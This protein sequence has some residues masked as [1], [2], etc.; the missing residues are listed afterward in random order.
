MKIFFTM[1]LLAFIPVFITSLLF[2]VFILELMDLFSN[3]WRYLAHDATIPSILTVSLLYL[4]KCISYALPISLLFSVS[5]TLGNLYMNNE[6]VA[7][8]AAGVSLYSL[9]IPFLLIGLISSIAIFFFDNS[10]VIDTLR[11]KNQL[12]RTLVHMSVS[13]SNTNVTVISSDTRVIYQSDYYND[14]KETLTK[15]TLII[16][17]EHFNFKSRID[18]D[19]GEWQQN[20][21]VFHNCRIIEWNPAHTQLTHRQ[22]KRLDSPELNEKPSTFRKTTRRIEEMKQNEALKWVQSLKQA[23]LPYRHALTEYYKKFFMALNPFIVA[24]ISAGIGSAFK[25]NILLMHLLTALILSVIYYVAQMI[26]VILSKG[27]YIPPL[28]GAGSSF[29]LF[30]AAGIYMFRRART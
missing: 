18:A 23:G 9:V 11:Q 21:W 15:V 4:P 10:V 30:F 20:S 16:R 17:D 27:G 13:Y 29:I 19:W 14:K 7:M 22:V 1:L 24:L 28:A 2:F 6:L 5:F 26:T 3:L 12:F 8:F 25:K